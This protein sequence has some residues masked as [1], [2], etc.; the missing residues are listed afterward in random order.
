M[1]GMKVK[2]AKTMRSLTRLPSKYGWLEIILVSVVAGGFSCG[3]SMLW[4]A[5]LD[6][7]AVFAFLGAIVGAAAV[8]FFSIGQQDRQQRRAVARER[9]QIKDYITAAGRQIDEHVTALFAA[10]SGA[11]DHMGR[12]LAGCQFA[13]YSITNLRDYLVQAIRYASHQGFLARAQLERSVEAC[14]HANNELE[15]ILKDADEFGKKF[16]LRKGRSAIVNLHNTM[17][18]L[19][20]Y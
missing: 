9:E 15:Q 4:R 17:N 20:D 5:G 10:E 7:N 2:L 6:K 16:D 13:I 11:S 19:P 18:N 12:L 14:D 8:V 3:M 1:A